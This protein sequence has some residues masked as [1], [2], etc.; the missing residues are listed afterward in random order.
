MIERMRMRM[1]MIMMMMMV[2][3]MTDTR[4][5]RKREV[6]YDKTDWEEKPRGRT[7]PPP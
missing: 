5:E 1:R 2:M 4:N 6:L 3:M 7:H